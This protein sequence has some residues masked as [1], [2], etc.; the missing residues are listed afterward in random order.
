MNSPQINT[1]DSLQVNTVDSPQVNTVDSLQVNTVDSPQ[2]NT[3]DSPQVNT[4]DSPQVNTVDSLQVNTV[5]SPQ[6]NTVDSPQVN[7]LL[8]F[9][10]LAT[11]L[12][13][14]KIILCPI[15]NIV[16][17]SL[18]SGLFPDDFKHA[19]VN[20]LFKKSTLLKENLNSYRPISDLS[21]I[22]K[23]L[24]KSCSKPSKISH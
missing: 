16:N 7:S 4:V 21:F 23:V 17:A 3:V 11:V 5:D 15:T 9:F 22:S 19:P 13:V 12:E 2:V 6:V 18:C 8:A 14:R 1:V 24:E 20:S 10:T